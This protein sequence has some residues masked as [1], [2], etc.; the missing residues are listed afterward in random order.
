MEDVFSGAQLALGL[1]RE[2][3]AGKPPV[4]AAAD[5]AIFPLPVLG[6]HRHH[7]TNIGA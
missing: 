2:L 7:L 1:L 4:V 3:L 5:T 6:M